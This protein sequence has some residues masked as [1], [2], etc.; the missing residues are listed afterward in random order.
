MATSKKS[1]DDARRV[2]IRGARLSFPHIFEPQERE[3]DDGTTRENFN[4]ALML[5]KDGLQTPRGASKPALDK[6]LKELK[7]AGK[8]ARQKA[9]GDDESKWPNIP[10]HRSFLKDGDNPD[11]SEREEYEGHFFINA[12]APVKRPPQVLTNRKDSDGEWI[13]AVEGQKLAPYA[14]CHVT[15]VIEVWGQKK[16]TKKNI[17]NRINATIEIVM[18][19]ADGEPFAAQRVNANDI[20]GDEEIGEEGDLD[21]YDDDDD[22]GGDDNLV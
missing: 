19:R 17:P 11:H 14:G 6:L 1:N 8:A 3:N 15:A 12:S 5:F 2:V 16:D 7:A 9:W 21:G 18:F 20:L 13:E 22:D 10:S 4:C